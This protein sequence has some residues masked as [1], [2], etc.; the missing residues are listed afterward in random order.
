MPLRA[1]N[2]NSYD[3]ATG[4]AASSLDDDGSSAHVVA[5]NHGN[6]RAVTPGGEPGKGSPSL[7]ALDRQRSQ[8]STPIRKRPQG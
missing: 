8:D 1:W 3:P 4:R 5:G 6:A 2:S 7:A